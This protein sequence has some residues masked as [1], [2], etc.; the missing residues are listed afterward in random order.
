MF[1]GLLAPSPLALKGR[2]CHGGEGSAA[3]SQDVRERLLQF[4]GGLS[5]TG[6]GGALSEVRQQFLIVGVDEP[7]GALAD[8]GMVIPYLQQPRRGR[9]DGLQ[10]RGRRATAPGG[11][12]NRGDQKVLLEEEIRKEKER[13]WT[14]ILSTRTLP[15]HKPTKNS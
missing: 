8:Q 15:P 1:S 10:L 14:W 9:I 6:T 11:R 3:S 12:R 4:P 2:A 7:V 13:W 5:L